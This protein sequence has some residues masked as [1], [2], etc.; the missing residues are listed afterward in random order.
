[1]LASATGAPSAKSAN[2]TDPVGGGVVREDVS[3]ADLHVLGVV[4]SEAKAAELA[5]TGLG[6]RA[7]EVDR[8]V[9]RG[10]GEPHW[11]RLP[12]TPATK[13][14]TEL[15]NGATTPLRLNRSRSGVGRY[16]AVWR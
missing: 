1:M 9:R 6:H 13:V 3:V 15:S 5:D 7:V 2:G 16:G 10:G 8:L 14:C 12:G 4:Q 11:H